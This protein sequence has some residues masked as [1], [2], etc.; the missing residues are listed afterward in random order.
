M[1]YK[2]LLLS[3]FGILAVAVYAVALCPMDC[4]IDGRC[5]AF[6][7]P[8]MCKYDSKEMCEAGTYHVQLYTAW[9]CTNDDGGKVFCSEG[10]TYTCAQWLKC[11]WILCIFPLPYHYIC[12]PG[13]TVDSLVIAHSVNCY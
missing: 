8:H 12:E 2:F 5:S 1:K 7:Q 10:V 4:P 6:L 9:K 3:V 13:S 11:E